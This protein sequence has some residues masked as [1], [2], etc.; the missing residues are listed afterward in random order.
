LKHEAEIDAVDDNGNQSLHWA[1]RKGHSETVKLMVSHKANVNAV[2]KHGQTLLYIAAGGKKDC[3][4]LCEM[5]LRYGA[6][7]D[8]ADKDGNQALH[9]AC[10]LGLTSTVKILLNYNAD[11]SA[12][13]SDGQTCLHK[14]VSSR[15]DCYD[16]FSF[17]L[18][19]HPYVNIV[20]SNRNTP[21]H[22]ALLNGKLEMAEQLLA[23]GS[24]CKVLNSCGET[25]LHSLCKSGMDG[26]EL[27]EDLISHGA[28]LYVTD[29]EGSVALHYALKNKLFKTSSLLFKKW[30][31][32]LEELLKF[33]IQKIAFSDLLYFAIDCDDSECCQKLL[34]I[35][36]DPNAATEKGQL[37]LHLAITK[38]KDAMTRLLLSHGAKVDKIK[39]GG[40]TALKRSA[41]R[42]TRS[43]TSLLQ[44][45]YDF[46][47]E[48]V[49]QGE[50]ALQIYLSSC[51]E[52][53]AVTV[54]VRVDVVGRDGAGKTSLTKSLT[55][56]EFDSD[57]L[58]TRGV[59]FDPKCQIIVKEACD[60]TTPLTH[61]HCK[62]MYDRNVIAIMADKLDTPKVKDDYFR[63]K[64][65]ERPKKKKDQID[66]V[67]LRRNPSLYR[68]L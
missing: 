39:I 4:E 57:E 2:D 33:N 61:E 51:K 24:D 37:P 47:N 42:G 36:V 66:L 10:D 46:P 44:G 9:V 8:A 19:K 56:Q 38:D 43:L 16:L 15:R 3:H 41:T 20:D 67:V 64:E 26:D 48:I 50:T 21:L 55:L 32:S 31:G 6:K 58:S 53:T 28:S 63:S 35:G 1:C 22:L 23:S 30:D 65:A 54:F 34:D 29:R 11:V 27:C 14:A 68:V 45:S 12:I 5:L 25:V 7:I 60:W 18:W 17:I 13:G 49:S 40:V 62:D 52:E 59:V